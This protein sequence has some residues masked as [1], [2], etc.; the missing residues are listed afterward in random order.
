MPICTPLICDR[1]LACACLT[2]SEA[3]DGLAIQ[4]SLSQS[5]SASVYDEDAFTIGNLGQF[6]VMLKE[7]ASLLDSSYMTR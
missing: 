4:P 7:Y 1:T 2:C 3:I 6:C 5:V